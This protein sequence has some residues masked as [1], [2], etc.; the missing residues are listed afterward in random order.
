MSRG[1]FPRITAAAIAGLSAGVAAA[2]VAPAGAQ[3]LPEGDGKALVQTICNACHDLSPIT[4]SGGFTRRDWEQVVQS[5]IDM[6]ATI[7]PDE[8]TVIVNYLTTSFPPKGAK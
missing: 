6:G 7:R 3:S 5:M 8:V 1:A 2:L 4:G